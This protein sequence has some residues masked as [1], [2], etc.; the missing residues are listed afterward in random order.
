[1][2]IKSQSIHNLGGHS[3]GKGKKKKKSRKNV[4]IKAPRGRRGSKMVWCHTG[5]I[6]KVSGPCQF[7]GNSIIK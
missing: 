4:P 1:M 3:Q 6:G 2:K 5:D 7:Q